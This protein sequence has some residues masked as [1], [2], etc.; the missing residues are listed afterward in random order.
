MGDGERDAR[1]IVAGRRVVAGG[2]RI[3]APD[4][5]RTNVTLGGTIVETGLPPGTGA[6]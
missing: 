1:L 4:E 6:P 2:Q 3:A 5:W